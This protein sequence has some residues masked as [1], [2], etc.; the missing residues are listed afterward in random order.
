MS[1]HTH[2]PVLL[3][4]GG[5]GERAE[6]NSGRREAPVAIISEESMALGER[7]D[8]RHRHE[9]LGLWAVGF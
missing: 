6:G 4:Q 9:N 2:T 3:E 7:P 5:L 8:V 1:A